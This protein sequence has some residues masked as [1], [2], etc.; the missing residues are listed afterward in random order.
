MWVR[1][2]PETSTRSGILTFL[3]DLSFVRAE[4][5]L[6]AWVAFPMVNLLETCT[7]IRGFPWNEALENNGGAFC[8]QQRR[9]FASSYRPKAS[10]SIAK[11]ALRRSMD[12]I[13]MRKRSIVSKA[14]KQS[15]A[16]LLLDTV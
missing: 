14:R 12:S 7:T 9:T 15:V 13:L 4:N 16:D 8:G 11:L 3:E 1:E 2:T 6:P 5:S 10:F